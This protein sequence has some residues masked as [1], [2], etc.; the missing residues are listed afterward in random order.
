M[1]TAHG[2]VRR[3]AA[4]ALTAALVVSGAVVAAAGPA[5]AAT[6]T[7][8]SSDVSSDLVTIDEG[9]VTWG[10]R[11]SWRGY[12][13]PGEMSEGLTANTA[14]EYLWKVEDGT[15]DPATK[16][17][18]LHTSG[19][20]HWTLHEGALDVT[21]SNLTLV[22]DGE[23]PQ[24]LVD[25]VSRSQ[26]GEMVDYGTIALV[27]LDLGDAQVATTDGSTSWTGLT[28]SL[29]HVGQEV[30]AGFYSSGAPF[31]TVSATYRGPGDKPE[32]AR[33]DFLRPGSIG[34]TQVA[35][36]TEDVLAGATTILPDTSRGV[37]HVASATS[38]RPYDATTLEPLGA[39]QPVAFYNGWT[40][41][42]GPVSLE[43]S[44]VVVGNS[45]GRL[46]AATWDPATG[47]YTTTVLSDTPGA[48]FTYS[49]SQGRVYV[50]SA[51]GV[52]VVR[53]T[54]AAGPSVMY[55][56]AWA[57]A[58]PSFSRP[59]IAVGPDGSL[60]IAQAS[61]VPQLVT[62][63]LVDGVRTATPSPLPGDYTNE[64]AAQA[65]FQYP[66]EVAADGTGF[67]L[68]NYQGRVYTVVADDEKRYT[69]SG[70]IVETGLNQVLRSTYDAWSGTWYLADWGATKVY[71]VR[72]D[73]HV[74]LTVPSLGTNVLE[75]V[76]VTGANGHLY[77]IAAREGDTGT[78]YG[79]FS[80]K[81][82]GLSPAITTAPEQPVVTL[83]DW[84]S[85]ATT[86]L[87]VAGTGTPAPTIQWQTRPVGATSVRSWTDIEGGTGTSL[88]LTL[89]VADQGRQYRAVLTNSVGRLGTDVLVAT[90]KT[91]PAV[92]FQP[93]DA[94]VTAGDD[95]TFQVMPKGT[96][97]PDITWQRQV[98]GYWQPIPQDDDNYA[99]D[100]GELVVL[101]T[102]VRQSGSLFRARLRNEVATTYSATVSLAVA[103]PSTVRRSIASG[104]VSW[105]V[106]ESFRSYVTGPIAH[107]EITV[108]GATTG[109]DGVLLW[110]VTGGTYDPVTRTTTATLGGTVRFTG[111]DGVLDLSIENPRLT[112]TGGTGVLTADVRSKDEST[113]KV[114]SYP[115]V[116]VADVDASSAVT[117][118]GSAV[119]VAN[120]PAVLATAGAPAFGGFYEAG[121]ALDAVSARLE[122]GGPVGGTTPPTTQ[123]VA[124]RTTLTLAR[125]AY[126]YGRTTTATVRVRTAAGAGAAGRVTVT[127]AGT[128]TTATLRSGAATVTLPPGIAPGRTTVSAVYT[129]ATGV[130][131]SRA[132]ASLTVT[133][134]RAKVALK[135][136]RSRTTH[137]K[138]AKARVTVTLPGTSTARPGGVVV[139]RDGSRILA[140]TRLRPAKHGKVTIRLPRL[141]KGKHLL[142]ASVTADGLH[143]SATS[144]KRRLV[145]R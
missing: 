22:V 135:L 43:S 103:A 99:I 14:G 34:L 29:A 112:L 81:Q 64:H 136:S 6:A 128:T 108:T 144:A 79:L 123:Q 36:R 23:D 143:R 11:T 30:F 91:P 118:G 114:V 138:R 78:A 40:S 28:S 57:G 26:S 12:A 83:H 111:H 69:R 125:A 102:N 19:K 100:G 4:H 124:S 1:H 38:L 80:W 35:S 49:A 18:E 142:R 55:T 106:K 33:D 70:P 31:D 74:Q 132:A 62:L 139:L 54:A 140:V 95:A 51:Q 37:L 61:V 85:T 96:P 120:A 73:N 60:V 82:E 89:G 66:T 2:A 88:T 94:S 105:G 145:V 48:A 52:L 20:V 13:G 86:T 109:D 84:E 141:G 59:S 67:L 15:Y 107:G 5:S 115:G 9:T 126:A 127:V 65:Y 58:A 68:T 3:I 27:D 93:A 44:G 130:E 24:V 77:A 134:A 117:V 104:T 90:V 42:P 101:D 137:K 63:D 116:A 47:E 121:T 16:H 122:L 133:K 97:Y 8:V 75:T 46:V 7:D 87:T 113:G 92:V 21:L 39:A 72:G 32:I 119:V 53:S 76:P 131:G 56:Y 110:P 25:T 129:G 71:G 98:D 10:V 17:L 45:G 41:Y 50:V